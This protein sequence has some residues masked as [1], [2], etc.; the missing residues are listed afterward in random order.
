VTRLRHGDG[1]QSI[2]DRDVVRD[3]R[4]GDRDAFGHL[5]RGYQGRLF[6]LVLMMVREPSGAEEAPQDAFVR[7]FTQIHQY[8]DQRPF[9]PWLASI[10]VRL[11]QNWLR[12]HGRT[13]RRE[14]TS[15]ESAEEP[16]ATA[17]A[18]TKLIADE[19]SRGLW[20]AVTALPSGERTAVILYYRD[21][22][23]VRDVAGALGVT[24]GTVKT[25]L[26]RARRHLRE[27]VD[28]ATLFHRETST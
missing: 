14:G 4:R 3:V 2:P 21:E 11:A 22:M 19:Q 23:A 25:R 10:A 8:E 27:R 13:A 7:A 5:V 9:H 1:G 15:L 6:G 28:A 26:F 18:L 16:G 24:T 20:Q 12:R 17:A